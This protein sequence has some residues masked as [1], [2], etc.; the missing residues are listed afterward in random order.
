MSEELA[1]VY[2]VYK[3]MLMNYMY[4]NFSLLHAKFD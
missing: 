3:Q 2:F 1:V 4:D